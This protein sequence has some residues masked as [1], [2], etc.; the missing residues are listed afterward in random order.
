MSTEVEFVENL[1]KASSGWGH[2]CLHISAS[3]SSRIFL[4][5]MSLMHLLFL[6]PP[7]TKRQQLQQAATAAVDAAGHTGTGE[8]SHTELTPV[9][10]ELQVVA[11][12][13]AKSASASSAASSA[14]V[15][16]CEGWSQSSKQD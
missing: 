4:Q 12:P 7:Q 3:M 16:C 15:N 13:V 10:S 6:I 9:K 2:C 5:L 14:N 11:A 8:G 1:Q